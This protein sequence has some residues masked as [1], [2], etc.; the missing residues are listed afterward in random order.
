[1]QR[2]QIAKSNSLRYTGPTAAA[3]AAQLPGNHVP[4]SHG[5]RRLRGI[6]HGHGDRPDST[7]LVIQDRPEG[8]INV[9]CWAGCSRQTIITAIEQ[10]TGFVIWEAWERNG[11]LPAAARTRKPNGP[12]VPS[13]GAKSEFSP[14][15]T[16]MARKSGDLQRIAS[17]LWNLRT[18]PIPSDEHHPARLWMAARNLWRPDLPPPGAIRWLPGEAHFQGKG[19]HTGAGSLVA[20]IAEPEA[21]Q[22]AWPGLPVPR[23]VQLVAIDAQ[24]APALDRPAEAGGLGKRSI[25]QTTNA[26]VVLGCPDLSLAKE[27]ARVAEGLADALALASR[28]PG[29]AIATLGTATMAGSNLGSWLATCSA[30]VTVHADADGSGE[31]AA[32]KLRRNVLAA[33][34][35]ANARLP[36]RGKDA[37][38]AAAASPFGPLPDGWIEYAATLVETTEWPRWEMARQAVT[39]LSEVTE[40]EA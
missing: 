7:S 18:L 29:P 10:A 20:L 28:Y 11:G 5:R 19:K 25:G 24:G 9:W 22:A 17:E 21:W 12:V 6:C 36:A 33:G 35:T 4:D 31:A 37:G 40:G 39:V 38:E 13:S 3:I 8:G 2:P 16:Q 1:M 23:G 26:V 34:G 30:G 27:A 14:E 15:K 32:R